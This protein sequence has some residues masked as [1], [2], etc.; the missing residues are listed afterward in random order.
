MA[1]YAWFI[2]ITTI[3]FGDYVPAYPPEQ[4]IVHAIIQLIVQ[5]FS[6]VTLAAIIDS[7]QS[8]IQNIDNGKRGICAKLLCCYNNINEKESYDVHNDSFSDGCDLQ[9]VNKYITDN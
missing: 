3:G 2:T 6:L 8:M 5:L 1:F 7:S 9:N 4:N